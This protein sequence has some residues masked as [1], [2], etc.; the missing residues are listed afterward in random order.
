MTPNTLLILGLLLFI[1]IS[2]LIAHFFLSEKK[3][4]IAI[5]FLLSLLLETIISLLRREVS[6]QVATL[7]GF[8]F[9]AFL[10]YYLTSHFSSKISDHKIAFSVVMSPLLLLCIPRFIDFNGSL[11]SLPEQFFHL[12]GIFVG[13]SLFKIKTYF[14]WVI[15]AVTSIACLFM[16]V[17]GYEMWLDKLNF[18]TYTGN[19]D[20]EE[21]ST[22]ILFKDTNNHVVDISKLKGKIVLLDFWNS[23]CG[24]CFRE[25]SQVQT[26]YDKYK[27]NANVKLYS[28]NSF[29]QDIDNDGD[30]LQLIKERS[31]TFP[32]LICKDKVLLKSLDI[33]KYPTLLIIN[34]KGVLVF[35]GDIEDAD[36]KIEALLK[37]NN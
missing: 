20:N 13:Y 12:F 32:V 18:G 26:M 14:K 30:A 24:A 15:L 21:I 27:T 17:K 29:F 22:E 37:E 25:F 28:V 33:I 34:R 23:K 10:M 16:Y 35:R 36:K 7:F 6:L 5:G 31:F 19:I 3:K 9:S 2:L 1:F 4:I 11:I 8:H